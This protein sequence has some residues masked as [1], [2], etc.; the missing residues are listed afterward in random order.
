MN[1]AGKIIVA[2]LIGTTFMTIYSYLISKKEKEQY[3]EPELL[4][5]LIDRSKYLP[6][7]PNKKVHLAGW[8]THY[9]IGILFVLFYRLLWKKSLEE[10]TI[11]KIF[12]IGAASGA[13]GILSWKFFFSEHD[14][15]PSNNRRGYYRQLFYAHLIFVAAAVLSYK[16][17]SPDLSG[18]KQ[19]FYKS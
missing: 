9:A 12:V 16:G 1:T 14:N 11:A 19:R 13:I 8:A 5:A 18:D 7:I 4:N 3:R 17:V 2:G 15:P 10:P 6:S